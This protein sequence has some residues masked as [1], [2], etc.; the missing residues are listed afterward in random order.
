MPTERASG[1]RAGAQGGEVSIPRSIK[2]RDLHRSNI[3]A[4][5]QL[6]VVL[7]WAPGALHYSSPSVYKQTDGFC[8][9]S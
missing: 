6:H 7:L 1:A 3:N 5:A 4:V 9:L 8:P 2:I